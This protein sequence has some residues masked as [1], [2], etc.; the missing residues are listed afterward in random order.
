MPNS[1]LWMMIV[2]AL[3]R[4]GWDSLKATWIRSHQGA[5]EAGDPRQ[6]LV[7]ANGKATVC[8]TREPPVEFIL[9]SPPYKWQWPWLEEKWPWLERA[10]TPSNI[11]SFKQKV[12]FTFNG[13][14]SEGVWVSSARYSPQT[15]PWQA[16]ANRRL[17]VESF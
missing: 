13:D 17:I 5:L 9:E 4:R 8:R 2:E 1:D 7:D 15:A 16:R 3:Q 11:F 14:N 12:R 10:M 6:P